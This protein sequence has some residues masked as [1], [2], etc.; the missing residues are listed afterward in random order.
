MISEV[1]LKAICGITDPV[2]LNNLNAN[3][4]KYSINTPLRIS[5]FL[6][7]VMHESGDFKVTKENLNYSSEGL[8]K[9]FKYYFP[10][11]TIADKY[12]HNPEA[13]ANYVYANRMGN[14]NEASGDGYKYCGRGYIQ[15]TGKS[16]YT[17]FKL[18]ISEDI[19]NSPALVGNSSLAMTSACW[20]WNTHKLNKLADINNIEG[21]TKTI[22]GGLNGQTDRVANFNKI[23]SILK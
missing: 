10:N 23:Y 18:T 5:H 19:I 3:L 7:Q 9:V 2:F 6:A 14:G 17:T 8:M 16:N 11:K 15:L 1:Q 21:I 12:A 22:N 4:D 13:I 20:Y